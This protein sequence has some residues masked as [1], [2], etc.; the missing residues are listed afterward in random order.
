MVTFELGDVEVDSCLDCGGIWLDTGELELLMAEAEKADELLKSFE[1]SDVSGEKRRKCPICFKKMVKIVVPLDY[2][3]VG[4]NSVKCEEKA[5]SS[6]GKGIFIDKCPG[7]DGLWFD[8][9]E[10]GEVMMAGKLD[11]DDKIFKL[12]GEIFSDDKG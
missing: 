8:K 9:G 10:L 4:D 2:E 6:T 12:L 1:V 7:N 3:A 5:E 11:E